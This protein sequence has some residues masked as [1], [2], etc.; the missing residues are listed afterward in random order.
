MAELYLILYETRKHEIIYR[1]VKYKPFFKKHTE[2]S[3]GWYVIDI[4]A[5]YKG[6]FISL[7]EFE[8]QFSEDMKELDKK[9]NKS[10]KHKSRVFK[11]ELKFKLKRFIDKH[12]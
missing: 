1:L 11:H 6:S 12:L 9:F 5:Y 3:M 10:F 8:K 4:Q 2:T 7:E